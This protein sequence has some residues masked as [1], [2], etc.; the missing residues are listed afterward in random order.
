MYSAVLY[1]SYCMYC[2]YVLYHMFVLYV[3]DDMY[4]TVCIVLY[5]M[6]V[7]VCT[8]CMYCTIC[9]VL[10]TL[11]YV[12]CIVCTTLLHFRLAHIQ[13]LS[14]GHQLIAAILKFLSYCLKLKV[15]RQYAIQPQLNTLNIL[16]GV[17][18]KVSVWHCM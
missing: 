17:L 4:C 12:Y 13:D 15:N 6:V 10:C 5:C 7:T 9:C 11:Q 3:L 2:M 14:R 1:C 18:N 8:A 16:L